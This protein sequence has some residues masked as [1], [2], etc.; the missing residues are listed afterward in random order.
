MAG[1][2]W[3]LLAALLIGALVAVLNIKPGDELSAVAGDALIK[4]ILGT[5]GV[6]GFFFLLQFFWF[7]PR[8]L[9]TDV[10]SGISELTLLRSDIAAYLSTWPDEVGWHAQVILHQGNVKGLIARAFALAQTGTVDE[11][12]LQKAMDEP[13]HSGLRESSRHRDRLVLVQAVLNEAA[14]V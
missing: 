14:R 2:A 11:G 10:H 12:D 5:F 4:G 3:P 1:N 7:T 13:M 6:L 8:R 9:D